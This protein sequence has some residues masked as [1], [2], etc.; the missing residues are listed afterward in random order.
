MSGIAQDF[1]DSDFDGPIT[2]LSFAEAQEEDRHWSNAHRRERYFQPRYDYEDYA[3]AYC[4]G[5]IGYAQYG[6]TFEDAERSLYANWLRIK[7]GSRLSLEEA[8][9]AIR[10]AWDRAARLDDPVD[11]PDA[12]AV[13]YV[14]EATVPAPG[15]AVPVFS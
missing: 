7:G 12:A 5:Y 14:R 2:V 6:G 11:G 3:P 13:E 9:P 8:M 4:V 15:A 10:A 1:D